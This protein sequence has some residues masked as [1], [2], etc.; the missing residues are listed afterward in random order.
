MS[1]LI[2]GINLMEE[3]KQASYFY[4]Q[5]PV[6]LLISMNMVYKLGFIGYSQMLPPIKALD[7]HVHV[8]DFACTHFPV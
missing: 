3:F 6:L 2:I 1:F 5:R 4:D 7:V 8:L